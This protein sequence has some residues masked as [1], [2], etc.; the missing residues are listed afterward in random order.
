MIDE[1]HVRDL[2]LIVEATIA[3]AAGLTVLTGETGAGKTALLT[4][5]KLLMGARADR[6]AVREGEAESCVEGRFFFDDAEHVVRRRVTSDGRS[7]VQ[8]DG[9]MASVGELAEVIAPSIDLCS[10]H[11]SQELLRPASHLRML[12]AWADTDALV[13]AYQQAFDAAQAAAAHLDKVRA[14]TQASA[15]QLEQASFILRQIEAVAPDAKEYDELTASLKKAE[16]VEALARAAQGAREALGGDGGALERAGAALAALEEGARADEALG[17]MADSLREAIF[18]LED[19]SREVSAYAEG[20][21]FEPGELARMQERVAAYQGLLR[22]YGPTVADALAR[23]DEARSRVQMVDEGE[24]LEAEAQA[25]VDRAEAALAQHAAALSAARADAAPAFAAKMCAVMAEL[26]MGSAEVSCAVEPLPRAQWGPTGADKVELAF[27]PAQN[28]QARPLSR[29]ASGGELS[30]VLLALHVVMEDKDDVSTLVFDEI[31]AG[32]GGATAVA[33]ADVL[34]RL[35]HTHQVLVVTHLAQV[36]ARAAK[37]YVVRKVEDEGVARTQLVEVRSEAREQ[38]IA[39]MLSGGGTE[40]SLV[41]AR[42]LL[43]RSKD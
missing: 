14:G 42:E 23:A 16:N 30:R 17:Q 28:M 1:I 37:H 22:S 40:A 8:M 38:E 41:H 12:D 43:A 11:D 20:V 9:R 21:E 26:E 10:Q 3:P 34:E 33:L 24:R 18:L 2:A 27:R 15:E 36:A 39:R 25:Q 7:R 35:A 4:S 19:A 6:T 32:V 31:D 13:Q 29:I 5:C